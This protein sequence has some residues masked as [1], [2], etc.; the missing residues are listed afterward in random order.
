MPFSRYCTRTAFFRR[1]K[2]IINNWLRRLCRQSLNVNL[3]G[4]SNGIHRD[5]SRM[6]RPSG[7]WWAVLE[8]V[9][10][11]IRA[12][13]R[14][15]PAWAK[16]YF[17]AMTTIEIAEIRR[18]KW[19]NYWFCVLGFLS[20]F[21]QQVINGLPIQAITGGLNFL[22]HCTKYCVMTIQFLTHPMMI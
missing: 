4:E 15:T 10:K 21:T 1:L 20:V 7:R 19:F 14:V 16:G 22:E 18:F 2:R 8:K 3:M 9:A 6:P 11:A 17:S 13:A 12:K 5:S